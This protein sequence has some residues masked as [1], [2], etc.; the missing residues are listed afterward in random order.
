MAIDVLEKARAKNVDLSVVDGRL[1]VRARAGALDDEL[2]QE[3]TLKK[4]LLIELLSEIQSSKADPDGNVIKPV[5]RVTAGSPLSFA[6]QRLWF[7]DQHEAGSSQYN[8]PTALTLRGDLNKGA[9]QKSL[10]ALLER[11]QVLRTTYTEVDEL[12]VQI[13]HPVMNVRIKELDLTHI[14][15]AAAAEEV[16]RLVRS[17]ANMAFNLRQDP[18]LRVSLLKLSANEHVLLFTM[19]HIA[20]D[21]WSV[22]VL[23]REFVAL[24]EAFHQGRDNPLA[25]L[26]IQYADFAHWQRETLRD[27][28]VAA[29]LGY[30][31]KELAAAPTVHRL[32]L[33]R[34]RPAEQN[35]EGRIVRQH[36][37]PA[38]RGRLNELARENG[39]TLFMLLECA[40]ALLLARWSHEDDIAIGTPIAGRTHSQLEP[41][42]GFFVNTL[43]FRHQFDGEQSFTHLLRDTRQKALDAYANQ[44]VPFDMVVERVQPK[45]SLGHSPLF[46]VLFALQNNEQATLDLPELS[47]GT[48]AGGQQ[49][50]KFDL[51]LAISESEAGLWLNWTYACS[52]FDAATVDRMS[53][54]FDALLRNIVAAPSTPIYRLALSSVADMKP[55]RAPMRQASNEWPEDLCLHRQ[56]EKHVE[57]QPHATALVFEDTSLT[58]QQLNERAN[59]AAHWLIQQGVGP[60]SIV[61]LCIDRS[62]DMVVAI[63]ATWKAGGAYLPIDPAYPSSRIDYILQDSKMSALL[64][65]SR[66]AGSHAFNVGAQLSLDDVH[67]VSDL[68]NSNPDIDGL[69]ADSLAYVIYTSGSTGTPKGVCIAHRSLSHLSHHLDEI[70]GQPAVWG[71][72]TSYVFDA[73]LQGLTRLGHGGCLIVLDDSHKLDVGRLASV[74]GKHP[75]D[76]V[77][78]TPSIVES[79]LDQ[80]CG[81][82]LPDLLIGGEAI[83][84]TLWKRVGEWQERHGRKAINVYGPTECCVDSTWAPI[85]GDM[86]HIGKALGDTTLRIL[87][88][89]GQFLP[90]G[91]PGELHIGGIGLA[92]GYLNRPELTASRFIDDGDSEARFYRTGDIVRWRADGNLEFLGRADG[93]VK[94]RGFRIELGEIEHQLNLLPAIRTSAVLAIDGDAKQKRLVAYVVPRQPMDA[95]FSEID[96]T[97]GLRAALEQSLAAHMV[98]SAFKILPRLPLNASGKLDKKGLA[99]LDATAHSDDHY[100]GPRNATEALLCEIWQT[101]LRVEKVGIHDNFFQ[102]GGDSILSIQVVARANKAGIP[103]TTRQLFASQTIA[104][105]AVGGEESATAA[106]APQ[107]AIQGTLKLLP[108][109]KAFLSAD[110]DHVQHFNQ[111]VLL[112]TPASFDFDALKSAVGSIL[113]R[114]DALRLRF[115][116]QG[117]DW[118]ATHEPLTDKMV[119]DSCLHEVLP[120]DVDGVGITQ[121]CEYHQR[122]FEVGKPPLLRAVYFQGAGSGRLLLVAHHLVVDGVSWRILLSD[123][124]QAY[125]AQQGGQAPSLAPK[126]SAFQQWG[127]ALAD[128]ATSEA[129]QEEVAFWHSQFADTIPSF[130]TDFEARHATQ[131]KTTR[132]VR[133][134]LSEG[135]TTKLLRECPAAYRTDIN[136]LLLSAVYLGMRR[137]THEPCLRVILEGHG[138]EDLFEALDTT[139]TVGWFTTTYPLTLRCD[140]VQIPGVIRSVKEHYRSIP[141]KGIGYGVLQHLAGDAMLVQA[142]KGSRAQVVFNYLGQFDQTFDEASLFQFAPESTGTDVDPERRRDQIL[143]LNGMVALGKLQFE[144]SYSDEEFTQ[145]N[146]E[147]LAGYLEDALR[148]VIEHC[149][150]SEG[151]T[152]VAERRE[153]GLLPSDFPMS[154]VSATEL[155]TWQARYKIENLYPAT[156]MQQGMLYHSMLDAS[157]YVSQIY[158]TFTGTLD[159]GLFR[160]AWQA[161]VDRYDI[162]RTVFVG[163]GEQLHQLVVPTAEVPWVEVDLRSLTEDQQAERFED[164]RQ[165]DK[166]LGFDASCAP[167]LRIGLFW[168]SDRRF[169]VL[170]SSHH[171]LLDGWSTPL[172]Y[173]DVMTAYQALLRGDTA[174]LPAV[175]P[176]SNYISWLQAQDRSA[177]ANYW[178][179]HLADVQR[180]TP[181]VIDRMPGERG[182]GHQARSVQL[183]REVSD[184]LQAFAKRSHTT[185]NTLVQLAWGLLLHRYSGEETVT[186]GATISGRPAAV[187]DIESMVGLFINT[188]PVK[189]SFKQTDVMPLIATLHKSFQ[190]SNDF[191]YL[192]LAEVQS[193][194]LVANHTPLFDSLIAFENFPIDAATGTT[195]DASNHG[196]AMDWLGSDEQT[197]Y[198]LTLVAT[199]QEVLTI[200]CRYRG[201]DFTEKAVEALLHGLV[202]F[203]TQLPISDSV[204][205]I[206]LPDDAFHAQLCQVALQPDDAAQPTDLVDDARA[207]VAPRTQTEADMLAIWQ[208]VL[209]VEISSIRD[210]FFDLGGNSLKAMRVAG[211]VAAHFGIERSLKA[212]FIH[213]T[214]ESLS[215]YVDG[216]KQV[217]RVHIPVVDKDG[218]IPLS[219]SQQQLWV[220]DQVNGGSPHYNMPFALRLRGNLDRSALR[221][222]LEAIIA[223]HAVLR[224]VFA[225]T[226]AGPVQVIQ[227]PDSIDFPVVDLTGL[228]EA[229]KAAAVAKHMSDEASTAFNLERDWLL[230]IRLLAQGEQDHVLLLTMH[231]IASD[232][233]SIGVLSSEFVALYTALREGR[234]ATLPELDIQYADFAHWQRTTFAD[235][236]ERQWKHWEH[237]LRGAPP[238]HA[239]PLDKLR[240]AQQ[241][242]TGAVHTHVIG[243]DLLAALNALGKRHDATPFMV[244][245]SAFATLLSRWSLETDIV[246]GSP[247]AGRTHKQLGVLIG[248][249]VNTLVFRH[250]LSPDKRFSDVLVESRKQA[251]EAFA[252]QDIPLEMLVDRL[253]P[254]RSLSHSPVVQVMFSLQNQNMGE[255]RLP[256]LEIEGVGESVPVAKFDLELDAVEQNGELHLGWR[257]ATSLFEAATIERMAASFTVL[258]RSIVEGP[259]RSLRELP[260]MD[261][262][263]RRHVVEVFS[264]TS[265][266]HP[267]ESLIQERFERVAATQPDAEAVAYDA[268]CLSY[269]ELNIRANRLAHLLLARGLKPGDRV[270]ICMER[271]PD[272]LVALMG[273][274]KAGAAY[275]MLD[276]DLPSARLAQRLQ[277]V[278]PAAIVAQAATQALLAEA[279][280]D[281]LRMDEAETRDA[282]ARAPAHNPD[283]RALGVNA[284]SL[285]CVAYASD[286]TGSR[287]GVMVEHR[288]VLN[289]WSSLGGV[290]GSADTPAQR[291]A[292]NASIA[293]DAS[294][295]PL[296][297]LL[298]GACVVLIPKDACA[299]GKRLLRY[300]V[301]QRVDLLDATPTQLQLLVSAGFLEADSGSRC[302]RVLVGGEPIP[303]ALNARMLAATNTVFHNVYGM[304][305]C[306]LASTSCV[307]TP[308][309]H[310]YDIGRPLDNTRVYILDEDR[311][312]VP[313][314]VMG[315]LYVGGAG[316]TRGYLNQP[317]LTA[318]RFVDDPFGT[319]LG[320][321]MYKSGDLGR[322][323][324]DGTIEFL[325][326]KDSQARIKGFYIDTGKVE[327]GLLACAGVQEAAVVTRKDPAGSDMLVAYLVPAAGHPLVPV[328][329]RA[330]LAVDLPEYM[331]PGTFVALDAVPRTPDGK[332]DLDA[333]PTP[334]RTDDQAYEA[335]I[336]EREEAL[337][338]IWQELFGLDRIGR[339]EN[340]FDIGGNSIRAI[341]TVMQA[342]KMGLNIKIGNIFKLQTIQ[343]ICGAADANVEAAPAAGEAGEASTPLSPYQH[344]VFE[345]GAAAA[346]C[347]HAQVEV[348]PDI[349]ETHFRQWVKGMLAEHGALLSVIQEKGGSHRIM[350]V[351]ANRELLRSVV[352]VHDVSGMRAE[353]VTADVEAARAHVERTLATLQGLLLRTALFVGDASSIGVLSVHR[354]LLDK[355]QWDTLSDQF[356]STFTST[357]R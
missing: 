357:M 295:Y 62:L 249:F 71:W 94:I 253:Q 150:P 170:W 92:R 136:E 291:V 118:V 240:P 227:P 109:Q 210:G 105:L 220:V 180:P 53:A 336:G 201:D 82:M 146:M 341:Q 233:W 133:I 343:G 86:P 272:A 235:E 69:T 246:I 261:V 100:A 121:R 178:K 17:E 224:T 107:R 123:L 203:L 77:D 163:E 307:V 292:L 294:V 108:I 339:N 9:L 73:S 41:L 149:A 355:A 252:N 314:G 281:V 98:P 135:E 7:I 87:S 15:E 345:S 171:M 85:T 263:A 125:R 350:R 75:V 269:G 106:E 316:V 266:P 72:M 315:E 198:K 277:D 327:A 120:A 337:A 114:H 157:A 131:R 286:R 76:I 338:R 184:Q 284:T 57:T 251:I 306:S 31:E 288:N 179:T 84:T 129:L 27:E 126:T 217:A 260:L 223:R 348:G 52:L 287:G 38:L 154:R 276:P 168:L 147:S 78:C 245:Q 35:F 188:I 124:E 91:V 152:P 127:A 356:R 46:Q 282:L 200:N 169:K 219:F 194:S 308:R 37:D 142:E 64:T 312:P 167:M 222:G 290:L 275:V 285:A 29:Q 208:D 242:F 175:A 25:P 6:Q 299:D 213:N 90:T 49:T 138:R 204:S 11:H 189:I 300:L 195:T 156:S 302:H 317:T 193:Y 205:V 313:V 191:G 207:E 173:R 81:S 187:A 247:V 298:S 265:N 278:A 326:R 47:I 322:W 66:V 26:G 264:G 39:A 162:L 132:I 63:L 61:G 353:A 333:L 232:G 238:L 112:A 51:E 239:L 116:S 119:D 130:P 309:L 332:R 21:G 342:S 243:R 159:T 16:E 48:L 344:A 241:K 196:L 354:A 164:A 19:H 192:P 12:A 236:M 80:E 303:S 346:G 258:L 36:L 117:D 214:I 13:V 74:L 56:F 234:D 340:F 67:A 329:L 289:L 65:N 20:S 55:Q 153:A 202:T 103:L 215:N 32:P 176:F 311:Q 22:G 347:W 128:Y 216:Q 283:A 320:A 151:S 40:F 165:R 301:Q 231:H 324:A 177:A 24:Y 34:P 33:D 70:T 144:L 111:S 256:G 199:M 110:R 182:R 18:M 54:S 280:T 296:A 351:Q 88:E 323:R 271:G 8:I 174:Q 254:E 228:D 330:Q 206:E 28:V 270:G 230:R 273:V 310:G 352:N 209:A 304:T 59:K 244:L 113:R 318:A 321:R 115:E 181:L 14:E 42:I 293:S 155:D 305:E 221:R 190:D 143:E 10:D 319:E 226:D 83:S 250:Q 43:V 97:A 30:W 349:T 248:F 148:S 237:V 166:A 5:A 79:W 225:R 58:Y 141:N 50:I 331:V 212:L 158:P 145:A 268:Q 1:K 297:Q 140:D 335:P 89:D 259:E 172:V 102:L 99:L 255:L 334:L 328:D 218:S 4:D 3:I 160:Q 44:D 186:F 134:G 104:E 95:G 23:T 93:Q 137:W 161:V 262:A 257:Y 197:N 325:G 229:A 101:L 274:L 2:R 122:A 211:H 279:S 45:R 139:Q 68:A 267:S 185:V 183:S 96:F 60:D